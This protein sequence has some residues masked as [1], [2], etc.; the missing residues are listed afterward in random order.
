MTTIKVDRHNSHFSIEISGHA[1]YAPRGQDIVCSGIS[2]LSFMINELITNEGQVIT[3]IM[4][5]GYCYFI[6]VLDK[7][8]SIASMNTIASGFRMLSEAYPNYVSFTSTDVD[9]RNGTS[10]RR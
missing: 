4:E 5:D 2:L 8:T 3:N 10:E 7:E 9:Y 1:N 6:F